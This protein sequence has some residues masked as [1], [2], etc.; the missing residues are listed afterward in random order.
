MS[1]KEPAMEA[2]A[3]ELDQQAA[4]ISVY[5]LNIM[6]GRFDDTTIRVS[7]N[8][9]VSINPELDTK[10]MPCMST[11]KSQNVVGYG[12]TSFR[13]TFLYAHDIESKALHLII[14]KMEFATMSIR[15]SG[16]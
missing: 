3:F 4:W 5:N 10:L 13:T 9:L 12:E 11:G 2:G 15:Q 6:P 16:K 1:N 14:Q 7:S 8:G